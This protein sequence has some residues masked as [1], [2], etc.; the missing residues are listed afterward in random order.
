VL[1][2]KIREWEDKEKGVVVGRTNHTCGPITVGTG[3]R[4]GAILVNRII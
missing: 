4:E 3:D 1:R 2:K